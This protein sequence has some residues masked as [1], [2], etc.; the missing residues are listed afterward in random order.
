[1]GHRKKSIFSRS[2]EKICSDQREKK[3]REKERMTPCKIKARGNS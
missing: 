2:I 3:K 1:M